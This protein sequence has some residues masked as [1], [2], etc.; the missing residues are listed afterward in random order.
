MSPG[1]VRQV[2]LTIL[3]GIYGFLPP[4]PPGPSSSKA[5]SSM[6]LLANRSVCAASPDMFLAG[7]GAQRT[8]LTVMSDSLITL[9]TIQ[10]VRACL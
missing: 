1:E 5:Y 9:I 4:P 10:V 7:V 8:T 3:S 2:C 6:P